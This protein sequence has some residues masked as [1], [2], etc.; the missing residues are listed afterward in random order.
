MGR[1]EVGVTVIYNVR[2][3]KWLDASVIS[4]RKCIKN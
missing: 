1:R 4:L 2:G 3:C